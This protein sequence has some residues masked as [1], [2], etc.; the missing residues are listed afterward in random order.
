MVVELLAG[1]DLFRNAVSEHKVLGIERSVCIG[2]LLWIHTLGSAQCWIS[3][4]SIFNLPV[5]G[6]CSW[7]STFYPIRL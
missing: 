3:V 6:H 2:F 5:T 1:S 4:R 7:N